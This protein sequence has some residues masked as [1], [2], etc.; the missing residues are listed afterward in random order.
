MNKKLIISAILVA[1][2]GLLAGRATAQEENFVISSFQDGYVTWSNV[3]PNLYYTVESKPN[4]NGTNIVWDGSN[5]VSQD[6]K[7]TDATITVPVG[8]FYRVVGSSNPMHTLTLSPS[9]GAMSAG[10]YAATNLSAVAPALSAS[11]IALNVTIFGVTGTLSTNGGCAYPAPV[12]E[13]GQTTE[14]TAGDDGSY[15]KG[16][17]WPNPR[18]TVG[19]GVDGTNCVT[20]NLTGLVWARNANLAGIAM[21][22]ADAIVYCTNLT[23]GG[24]NDWRLPNVREMQ[25]LIDYGRNTPALCNT[26]GTGKWSEN[27]PFTGVQSSDYYW[28]STTYDLLSDD[29]AWNVY[30][31]IGQVIIDVKAGALLYVWPVRGGQ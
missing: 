22:W 30:L 8:V 31:S 4:L 23:Y 16:A 9:N 14:Y 20:D 24:T 29:Y 12:P 17:T 2:V 10:Y 5:R 6:V 21:T 18:F 27:D 11:N 15:K 1:M 3:N 7:T 28:S 19:T 25:S 26:S 13:T